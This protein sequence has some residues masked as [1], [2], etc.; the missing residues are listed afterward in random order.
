MARLLVVFRPVIS[1]PSARKKARLLPISLCGFNIN[2]ETGWTPSTFVSSRGDRSKKQAARPEDFMDEEDLQ[3]IKESRNLVDN[4]EEMDFM[5]GTQK[6]LRDKDD[7]DESDK[8][9]VQ[10]SYIYS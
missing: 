4:T 1:T 3:D 7:V 2:N 10:T 9:Y 6:E 5:G 8:E